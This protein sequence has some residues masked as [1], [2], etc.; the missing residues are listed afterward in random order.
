MMTRS[1]PG[2]GG[3]YGLGYGIASNYGQPAIN[4]SGANSG[5]MAYYFL[6]TVRRTGFVVASNSSRAAPLHLTILG[7]WSDAEFGPSQRR[8]YPPDPRWDLIAIATFALAGVLALPLLLL[9]GRLAWQA[10]RARRVRAA[11]PAVRTLLTALP[12][13]VWLLFIWYTIYSPLPLYLP[14]GFPDFWPSPAVL[15]LMAVLALW[16]VYRAVAAYLRPA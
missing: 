11:R 1:Q 5:W 12:W 4:H 8:A 2:T 16:V 10:R 6:D 13:L 3:G 9:A 7:L 14:Q 15:V